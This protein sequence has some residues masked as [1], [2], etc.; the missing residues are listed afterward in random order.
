MR[1]LV[2]LLLLACARGSPEAA[3]RARLGVPDSAKQVLVFAQNA[4][5][6]I[7]WQKTFPD[8]YDS[9]VADIFGGAQQILLAQPR[10]R[11]AIAEMAYLRREL[12][13]H[14]E[15]TPTWKVRAA[16]GQLRVVGGGM[17]SPDTL[18]PSTELL[19]RDFM[20]GRAVADSI[21][22]P[23]TGAA[24][25]PDSFG[26]AATVP[27]LLA[28]LG[29]SAVFL[30][31]IDGAPTLFEDLSGKRRHALPGST[32]ARLRDLGSADFIW[33]G[34]GGG[35]LLA[36]WQ[37]RGI[38]CTGD[39]IDYDEPFQPAGGHLGPFKGDD[40]GFTDGRIE[41]YRSAL[42]PFA[43]TPYLLVPVGCD[44]Q[45]PKPRLI[46]Y[47]DGYNR[48]HAGAFAVAAS[49]DDYVQ[50]V[51]AHAADLP[52]IEADLTPY[53]MGFYGSRPGLKRAVR[54]AAR[55]FLAAEPFAAALGMPQPA[56]EALAELTLSN[57]HDFITGT[58]TDEV[59]GGEQL[60]LARRAQ[61]AGEEALAEVARALSARIPSAPGAVARVLALNPS[62]AAQGALAEVAS[63]QPLHAGDA[64]VESGAGSLRIGVPDLPPFSW[65]AVDLLP[66]SLAVAPQV[67]LVE[68]GDAVVLSNARVRAVIAKAGITSLVIDGQELLAGPSLLFKDYADDGGLWRLGHEMPGC[69]LRPLEAPAAGG[70]LEV[71]LASPLSAVVAI[72]SPQGAREVRLDAGAAALDVAVEA[73]AP[74]GVTRN[75]TF[76]LAEVGPLFASQPGGVA[77]RQGDLLFAPTFWPAVDFALAGST[78]LLLRQATGV[79]FAGGT[80]EV[81]AVRDARSEACDVLGGSGS[82]PGVHRI[83][84]RLGRAAGPAEAARA[85]QAFDRPAIVIAV[86]LPSGAGDLPAAQQ[87]VRLDGPGLVSAV[88]P[89]ERGRGAILRA[90]LFSAPLTLTLLGPLRGRPLSRSDSTESDIA[91]AGSLAFDPAA[92]ALQ[93]VRL[94]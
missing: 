34:P 36:H 61:A 38:Y 88:K 26:H 65:R 32:A 86:P 16:R 13:V 64:Q 33:R 28:S 30:G 63:S 47:L 50:L 85:A 42:A 24:W 22:A 8:Y 14:P 12:L 74:M 84:W 15:R 79:R 1:C 29:Y 41:S 43:R 71:K 78:A 49:F 75:V 17:T 3:L 6:D 68:A 60:P 81:M 72:R 45:H 10:A 77:R 69:K 87:L 55:A 21:G 2:L 9:Y 57:H 94:R 70:A 53:F 89:A 11:Y 91:S 67:S 66:G 23:L 27:D 40:P 31:R 48:R 7:D 5:L 19:L 44:F 37:P 54:D 56:P 76:A 59:L 73:A 39:D 52:E 80:L 93:T 92:G 46:E 90:Q 20:Y 51:L 58:S 25:L 4:H 82:D 62:S 35:R 83:E 18:L